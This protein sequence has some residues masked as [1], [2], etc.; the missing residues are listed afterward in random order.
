MLTYS[1]YKFT[2]FWAVYDGDELLC[3]TVYLKGA[4]AVV[5]RINGE[6]PEP[7]KRK[8][9]KKPPPAPPKPPSLRDLTLSHILDAAINAQG[10]EM[11]PQEILAHIEALAREGL[12]VSTVTPP[13]N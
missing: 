13:Q 5:E 11:D 1:R 10:D 3:V 8:Q 7:P 4:M 6:K 9:A 2:R 12:R